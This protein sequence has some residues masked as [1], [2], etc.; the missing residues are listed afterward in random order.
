LAEQ[1][2][3]LARITQ[4]LELALAAPQRA[5]DGCGGH[6]QQQCQRQQPAG[7]RPLAGRQGPDAWLDLALRSGP[8]G[9]AFG[10]KPD[11]LNL[12]KVAAAPGGAPGCWI[13][14]LAG[15]G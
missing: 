1:L 2:G 13:P 12:A 8:Y 15:G 5:G 14:D 11:G 7:Q 9:D 4:P 3:L 6:A 10:L